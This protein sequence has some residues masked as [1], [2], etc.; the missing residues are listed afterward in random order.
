MK[1]L[2]ILLLL[3]CNTLKKSSS[4]HLSQGALSKSETNKVD[5]TSKGNVS[6]NSMLTKEWFEN[7]K[8]TINLKKDTINNITNVYPSS[9][10]YESSKGNSETEQKGIDSNWVKNAIFDAS[11]SSDSTNVKHDI[12]TSS[13]KTQTDWKLYLLI[14]IVIYL[15]LKE[16]PF[17]IRIHG[18][19]TRA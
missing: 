11:K 5:T 9:I 7:L 12:D 14:V 13:K 8:T 2:V 6:T 1:Y 4:D 3:S 18:T 15:A 16:L 10:V 17:K 19:K